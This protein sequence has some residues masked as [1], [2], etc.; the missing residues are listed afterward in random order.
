MTGQS[1]T[2]TPKVSVVDADSLSVGPFTPHTLNPE[3][4]AAL[5]QLT[6]AVREGVTVALTGM[7][8]KISEQLQAFRAAARSL[9]PDP[10]PDL[11]MSPRAVALRARQNR[12]TGPRGNPRQHRRR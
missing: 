8:K 6:V 7:G 11:D 10:E 5:G 1:D 4:V 9:E 2:P 12:H 3:T